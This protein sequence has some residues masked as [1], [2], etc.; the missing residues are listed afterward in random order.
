[1]RSDS[2]RELLEAIKIV[3][4]SGHYFS[5]GITAKI[6]Q[7]LTREEYTRLGFKDLP[8]LS[9]DDVTFLR[10]L[11]EENTMKEIAAKMNTTLRSVEHRKDNLYQ[12]LNKRNVTGLMKYAIVIGI[13]DPFEWEQSKPH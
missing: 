12:L 10:L 4:A 3:A 7:A 2:K 9:D 11:C 8:S 13:F 6:A 1:M 5:S